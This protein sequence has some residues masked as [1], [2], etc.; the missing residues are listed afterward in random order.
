MKLFKTLSIAA[1]TAVLLSSCNSDPSNSQTL[2]MSMLYYVTSAT[3]EAYSLGLSEFALD[4]SHTSDCEI[5][6]NNVLVP[7][8]GNSTSFKFE[9]LTMSGT[10]SGFKLASGSTAASKIV[11]NIEGPWMNTVYTMNDGTIDMLAMNRTPIFFSITN[12]VGPD[13]DAVT[14]SEAGKNLF[15]ISI[16]EADIN[17]DNRTLDFLIDNAEFKTDMSESIRLKGIKFKIVG[18]RLS[19]SA[20]EL[21]VYLKSSSTASASHKVLNLRASGKIGGDYSVSF[22]WQEIDGEGDTTD[23]NV[24]STLKT[25]LP[26]NTDK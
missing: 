20:D 8:L 26:T 13:G 18:D 2:N 22:V 4:Y 5:T 11:C 24:S 25:L 14:S 17:N 3:G 10:Q 16:N 12:A 21:P 9:D 1:L 7:G 23:Y 15:M 6:A 19:F